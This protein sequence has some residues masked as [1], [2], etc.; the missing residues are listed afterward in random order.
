M[1]TRLLFS[2][3]CDGQ[4]RPGC[5]CATP[6]KLYPELSL[7]MP[8]HDVPAA[9]CHYAR[10]YALP[11]ASEVFQGSAAFWCD[12][13]F[14][15]HFD[16]FCP[17]FFEPRRESPCS[18]PWGG[19]TG[20]RL[21]R[22]NLSSRIHLRI[23]FFSIFWKIGISKNH[24]S[25]PHCSH[26]HFPQTHPQTPRQDGEKGSA[27]TPPRGLTAPKKTRPHVCPLG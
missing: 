12:A 16:L 3:Q 17:L 20:G 10:G 4:D 14:G 7:F 24:P 1:V 5:A 18:V 2:V 9:P 11:C 26:H 21:I 8:P 19:G 13:M 25:N 27:Q 22:I 15:A 6:P 23:I